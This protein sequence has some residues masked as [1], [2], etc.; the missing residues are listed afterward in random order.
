MINFFF[1]EAFKL[2]HKLRSWLGPLLIMI[3]VLVAFP[4][5]IDTEKDL[6]KIKKI[7]KK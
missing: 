5:S 3:L 1:S 6:V 4:L 2:Q 7:M